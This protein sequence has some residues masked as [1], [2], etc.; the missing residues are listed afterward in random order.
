M[1]QS[2]WIEALELCLQSLLGLSVDAVVR[3][4]PIAWCG[5]RVVQLLHARA[6]ARL[7][8]EFERR[9]EEVDVQPRAGVQLR[10]GLRRFGTAQAAVA[11]QPPHD[12]AVLL[13][14][15]GLVVLLV[16]ARACLHELTGLAVVEDRLV[17]E[18]TIVVRVHAEHGKG[19]LFLG[20]GQRLDHQRLIAQRHGHAFGPPT[21]DVG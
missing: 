21:G 10:Q 7:G 1:Q 8:L 4:K 14:D 18:G 6:V 5:R 17:H 2:H 3:E 19:K 13:L 12:G 11:H 20:D 9:L 16:G 15:P